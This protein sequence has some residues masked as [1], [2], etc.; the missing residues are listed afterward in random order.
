MTTPNGNDL[1]LPFEPT[2]PF[3]INEPLTFSGGVVVAAMFLEINGH[4]HPAVMFRFARHDGTGFHPPMVLA[5]DSVADLRAL[6]ALVEQAV[7][8]AIEQTT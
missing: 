1:N 3:Q 5:C 8:H 6:P 4:K 2:D 7:T